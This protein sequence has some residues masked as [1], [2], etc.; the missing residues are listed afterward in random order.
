M[1]VKCTKMATKILCTDRIVLSLKQTKLRYNHI[2]SSLYTFQR[3][4]IHIHKCG[5]NSIFNRSLNSF[6]NNNHQ[7]ATFC[8]QLKKQKDEQDEFEQEETEGTNQDTTANK[9]EEDEIEEEYEEYDEEDGDEQ[10]EEDT[11]EY[12]YEY[13]TDDEFEQE[14]DEGSIKS[15]DDESIQINEQ[16]ESKQES[17]ISENFDFVNY[18][19]NVMNELFINLPSEGRIEGK[20]VEG[21][22][23]PLILK[24]LE[25]FDDDIHNKFTLMHNDMD[26]LFKTAYQT[27]MENE[28]ELR[29]IINLAFDKLNVYT[30]YI[31]NNFD[32]RHSP[33]HYL[34]R[35]L[36]VDH[37]K[38]VYLTMRKIMYYKYPEWVES[39]NWAKEEM[40]DH[41]KR[42]FIISEKL[43]IGLENLENTQASI[44]END[45]QDGN[46]EVEESVAD[47][48]NDTVGD[49]LNEDVD[50]QIQEKQVEA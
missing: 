6:Y 50:E 13:E 14:P 27:L 25:R 46:Q 8:S 44:D 23:S 37:G 31:E 49:D 34:M 39:D 10:D 36:R 47:D 18:S 41:N 7:I 24:P 26:N 35:Q 4:N 19:Q 42:K 12:E 16:Q 20:P 29:D 9:D 3:Q 1:R 17:E 15:K 28:S 33:K 45:E 22:I 30:F 32:L 40:S 38:I 48:G 5:T 43:G 2:K 11:D 21:Y